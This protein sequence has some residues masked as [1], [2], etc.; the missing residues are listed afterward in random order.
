MLFERVLFVLLDPAEAKLEVMVWLNFGRKERI[1]YF[2]VEFNLKQDGAGLEDEADGVC[3]ENA[4]NEGQINRAS[5]HLALNPK[6]IV[7]LL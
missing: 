6:I 5:G 7:Q 2:M 1:P 4:T 3:M